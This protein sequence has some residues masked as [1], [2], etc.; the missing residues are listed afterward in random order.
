MSRS[1][2][3]FRWW[4][5]DP[6]DVLHRQARANADRTRR[7][8]ASELPDSIVGRYYAI[9]N[10]RFRVMATDLALGFAALVAALP[11][12][13]PTA[14]IGLLAAI[15][16]PM[17][18][19]FSFLVVR[20]VRLWLRDVFAQTHRI[21][22]DLDHEPPEAAYQATAEAFISF[23]RLANLLTLAGFSTYLA[24]GG[25]AAYLLQPQATRVLGIVGCFAVAACGIWRL[26][27]R[28][29]VLRQELVSAY[30]GPL[31]AAYR[32]DLEARLDEIRQRNEGAIGRWLI[33]HVRP[34][35]LRDFL[36]STK[37]HD[38]LSVTFWIGIF[39]C[40]VLRLEGMAKPQMTAVALSWALGLVVVSIL[41]TLGS[42]HRRR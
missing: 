8:L 30:T 14:S 5:T 9:R 16:A 35:E 27:F 23:R 24:F 19:V 13:T 39:A 4:I 10:D 36:C 21:L 11:P 18:L 17:A 3:G 15:A 28:S 6:R 42:S 33:D 25:I 26:Y 34:T 40:T 29:E 2:A 32:E 1:P 20:K 37:F 7:L 38:C 31:D 41:S 12:E 22:A